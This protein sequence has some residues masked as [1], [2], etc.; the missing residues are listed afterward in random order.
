M[1]KHTYLYTHILHMLLEHAVK[2]Y[3]ATQYTS[4]KYLLSYSKNIIKK[5]YK[6]YGFITLLHIVCKM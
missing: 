2:K 1:A 5:S 6:V 4:T 3:T